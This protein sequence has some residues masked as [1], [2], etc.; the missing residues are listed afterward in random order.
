MSFLDKFPLVQ[1][2]LLSFYQGML[3]DRADRPS[4]PT[5]WLPLLLIGAALLLRVLT[6]QGWVTGWPNFSPLVAF[7]FVGAVM[8]PKP[9][10]WWAWPLMLMGVD[11]LCDGASFWKLTQGR[12]EILLAYGC[13]L[14]CAWWGSRFR[15][16]AGVLETLG[17]TL[18][19]SVLFY[20]VTNTLCWW[21]EPYYTKNAAGWVQALT[22]GV[23]GPFPSTLVF[24]RNSL[25]ADLI[26]TGVLLLIYNAEALAR[27]L[28]AIP[29]RWRDAGELGMAGAR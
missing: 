25:A 29:W 12:P 14:F 19:C 24:F 17:G 10:P 15:G 13:Y 3:K 5:I 8:F 28:R 26:G 6:Q 4:V 21:V 2:R 9:L 11:W 1:R 23:P 7:A 16:R 27:N 18:A 20:L 22:V